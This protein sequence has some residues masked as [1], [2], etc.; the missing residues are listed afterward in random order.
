MSTLAAFLSRMSV[1]HIAVAA[2]PIPEFIDVDGKKR[3]TK[4]SDGRLIY[5]TLFGIENFWRW[6]GDS[7]TVD[8]DGRPRVFLHGTKG[9]FSKFEHVD[10]EERVSGIDPTAPIGFHF[11]EDP[12]VANRFAEGLYTQKWKKASGSVMPVY[13]RTESVLEITETEMYN[14]MMSHNWGQDSSVEFAVGQYAYEN[15][16]DE[17]SVWSDYDSNE[18]F[19]SGINK[20][21][22]DIER[23]AEEPDFTLVHSMAEWFRTQMK[24]Q[25]HDSVMYKNEVEGGIAWIVLDPDQ[26]KSATGNNGTFA[27][28]SASITASFEATAVSKKDKLKAQQKAAQSAPQPAPQVRP[29]KQTVVSLNLAKV[30]GLS[31]QFA[32]YATSLLDALAK[33]T[34]FSDIA[35][36]GIPVAGGGKLRTQ[37]NRMTENQALRSV[38]YAK[39]TDDANNRHWRFYYDVASTAVALLDIFD[40]DGNKIDKQQI[41]R[42]VQRSRVFRSNYK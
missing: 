27:P 29:S 22:L 40:K 24:A 23:S 33:G 30:D 16:T 19:R 41:E 26:I 17:D 34:S 18:V 15:N 21:A 7:R 2:E 35:S 5:P 28:R 39:L 25:G 36:Q 11:T 37:L 1:P 3:P 10:G 32:S 14:A 20:S 12:N 42:L 8:T 9:N 4:N 31:E 38:V 6:F 13:L